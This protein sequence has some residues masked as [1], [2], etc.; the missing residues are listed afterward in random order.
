MKKIIVA[1]YSKTGNT[2][3]IACLIVEGVKKV[4]G[5]TAELRHVETIDAKE[6]AEADGFVF[7]SPAYFSMMAGPMMTLLTEFYFVRDKLG[8]KPMAAFATGGGSQTKTIANIESVLKAFNPKLIQPGLAIGP[9][10][11]RQTN[12][13]LGHSEKTLPKPLKSQKQSNLKEK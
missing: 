13:K 7:G 3:K 1:Y 2:E 6:A 11:L 10:I 12:S 4:S 9:L 5:I 8:G